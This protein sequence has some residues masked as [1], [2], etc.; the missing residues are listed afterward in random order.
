MNCSWLMARS[1]LSLHLWMWQPSSHSMSPLSVMVNLFQ[2]WVAVRSDS[3][4]ESDVRRRSS[5]LVAE[6]DTPVADHLVYT[7]QSDLHLE[8]LRDRYASWRWIYHC[9]PT[10]CSP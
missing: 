10:C 5:T 3:A 4:L 7:L 8:N 6:M 2:I 1:F 9:L